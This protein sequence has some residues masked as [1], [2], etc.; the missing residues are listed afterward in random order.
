MSRLGGWFRAA[1]KD[2]EPP[3]QVQVEKERQ[4]MIEALDWA[5]L[6]MNDDIDG[7]FAALSKGNSAFH[8]LGAA[9]T[10]MMR[11][12]LGFEKSVMVE[13]MERLAA[14]EPRTW[15]EQ[16]RAE[17]IG[18]REGSVYPVGMEYELIRAETQL[19]GAVVGVLHE[20]LV[21]AMKSFYKMRKA[22]VTLDGIIAHENKIAGDAVLVPPKDGARLEKAVQKNKENSPKDDS[23]PEFVDAKETQSGMQTPL[24][25][26][27]AA[28]TPAAATPAD[29]EKGVRLDGKK[30]VELTDPVDVFIHSGANMAFGF[31]LL[32]LTL[33]PPAFGKILSVVGFRGDRP[34]GV[35]MLWNN[36]E[37]TNIYGGLSGMIVLMYYNVLLGTVDILPHERDFDELAATV[38]PPTQRCIDLLATMRARYPDSRLW[39]IEEARQ[40]AAER[41][42]PEAISLLSTG[43]ASK[44][45]QVAALNDFELA[46]DATYIQDWAMSR[47]MFLRCKEVNDWSPAFYTYLAGS[48][49]LELYRDELVR[50]GKET[51]EARKFKKQ[52]EA[53]F[54]EATPLVGKKKFMARQL[55][56]ETF[57]QRRIKRWEERAA[58]FKV[59]LV[60]AVGVSPAMEMTYITN[61]IK[62]MSV[63]EIDRALGNLAWERCPA[64]D[65]IRAEEDEAGSWA[66]IMAALERSKGNFEAAKAVLDEHVT[67]YDK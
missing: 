4:D 55:P 2:D 27:T 63:G 7:A 38:G 3:P 36:T 22:Y 59:D 67:K 18:P 66:V 42:I 52:A 28:A 21:E 51:S 41:R 23:E 17:K 15:E 49:S 5:Q 10:F 24:D 65:K 39:R 45:K 40:L 47:D 48:A 14:V 20:N 58:A 16:K 43:P 60:D 44:M 26:T 56:L 29:S 30:E 37:H 34:K 31:I 64:G 25:F 11:S 50:E 46:L 53:Y 57:L 13:T 12:V 61:G 62:K 1:V 8:R 19:M 33:V 35:S 9:V 32:M 6:I 54:K